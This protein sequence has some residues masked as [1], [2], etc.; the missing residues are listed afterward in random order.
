MRPRSSPPRGCNSMCSSSLVEFPHPFVSSS[1]SQLTSSLWMVSPWWVP[2]TST[3]FN[4]TTNTRGPK[5]PDPQYRLRMHAIFNVTSSREERENTHNGFR[6]NPDPWHTPTR[7]DRPRDR[8]LPST[9]GGKHWIGQMERKGT[10][11]AQR[12]NGTKKDSPTQYDG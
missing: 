5:K 9:N 11:N 7:A 10:N 2:R 1:N 4:R 8:A 12:T 6:T 3:W